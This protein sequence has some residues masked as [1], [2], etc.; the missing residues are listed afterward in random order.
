MVLASTDVHEHALFV[1][2]R[3]L[4]AMGFSPVLAGAE[5]NPVDIVRVAQA[6]SARALVVAT[7]NGL[8]LEIGKVLRQELDRLGLRIPVFMGGKL[9]QALDGEALPVDVSQDL[10]ALGLVPCPTIPELLHRLD[11]LTP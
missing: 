4:E 8:A 10:S 2:Q 3:G 6:Q 11:D 5:M 9:N 1:I 7:Y